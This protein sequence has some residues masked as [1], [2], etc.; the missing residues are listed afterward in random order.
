MCRATLEARQKRVAGLQRRAEAAAAAAQNDG[1]RLEDDAAN[2]QRL[3]ALRQAR[4]DLGF[5]CFRKLDMG[6]MLGQ[7]L[8][9]NCVWNQG[10]W[11]C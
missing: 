2:M 3:D 8:L 7:R 5:M 6:V 4:A 1:K 9:Y 11:D 10:G